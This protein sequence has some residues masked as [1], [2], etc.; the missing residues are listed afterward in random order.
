ML[1]ARARATGAM[2]EVNEK[3]ACP[4]AR[5]LRAFADAGVPIVASTDSHNCA[6]VGVYDRVRQITSDAA[7]IAEP[8]CASC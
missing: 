3:W 2:V 1:A 6:D 4:S 7:A 8:P 5:S